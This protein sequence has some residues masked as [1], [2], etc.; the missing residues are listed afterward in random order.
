MAVGPG[1]EI[2]RAFIDVS[3]KS[4]SALKSLG[5]ISGAAAGAGAALAAIPAAAAVAGS[6]VAVIAGSFAGVGDAMDAYQKDQDAATDKMLE[7]KGITTDYGKAMA[8]LSPAQRELTKQLINMKKPI[9]ELNKVSAEAFLPGVTAMLKDSE[10]LFPIFK[11][12]LKDTGQIMGDTARDMGRLFKSQEFQDDLKALL[13]NTKPVTKAIGDSFVQLM[14]SVVDF[15]GSMKDTSKGVA[16]FIKDVSDGITGFLENL[17]PYD[18]NFASIWKSAG[19]IVKVVLPAVGSAIGKLAEAVDPIFS[20]IASFMEDHKDELDN[21]ILAILGFYGVIKG[22][23]VATA[24]GRMVTGVITAWGRLPAGARTAALGIGAAFVGIGI[25]DKLLP[26]VQAAVDADP[27]KSFRDYTDNQRQD[28]SDWWD[29]ILDPGSALADLK[30]ELDA[31]PDNFSHSPF[32][33]FFGTDL[34]NWWGTLWGKDGAIATAVTDFGGWLYT[35]LAVEPAQ[36]AQDMLNGIGMV[37][38]NSFDT[39]AKPFQDGWNSIVAWF[40]SFFGINS[41]STLFFG[42][43]IDIVTG[44]INGLSGLPGQALAIFNSAKDVAVAKMGEFRDWVTMIAGQ[45]VTGI[46][47]WISTLPISIS[48]WLGTARD[49]AVARMTEMKDGVVKG[50]QDLVFGL[51]GWFATL[52]GQARAWFNLAASNVGAAWDRIRELT[53]APVRF[54][55]DTVIN[56]GIVGVWN[57]LVDKIGV[58][59]RLNNVPLPFAAGGPVMGA[60]T[61]TSDSIPALLSN[62]E[63]VLTAREVQGLGGHAS[64][65]AIRAVARE[66]RFADGGAV[67]KPKGQGKV[68]G[69]GTFGANLNGSASADITSLFTDPVGF[70]AGKFNDVKGLLGGIPFAGQ[71]GQMISSIAGKIVDNTVEKAKSL[72]EGLFTGGGGG[73]G[74]PGTPGSGPVVDQVRAAMAAFGWASGPQWDALSWLISHESGWRPTAQN[75]TSTAY[76]LFQFLN[77]TWGSVGGSKTGNPGLQ[78]TYGARYIR[79][80]YGTPTGAKAFWQAHHWYDQGGILP[81]GASVAINGTGKPER[82]LTDDQ[83]KKVQGGN[84]YNITMQIDPTKVKSMDDLIRLVDNLKQTSRAGGRTL[85]GSRR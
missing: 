7:A 59:G 40:K 3:V 15:G 46:G 19:R 55:V 38:Q 9:D 77:S 25:A 31:F 64:V 66:N 45:A 65:E 2:G 6:A 82:V 76:G 75:P 14:G 62:G 37:F 54:V 42:F 61:A 78:A 73:G 10:G 49:W 72:V 26:E 74:A 1:F 30:G 4:A 60:G 68:I 84:T 79:S 50:A 41:P 23:G 48:N 33:Q 12:H 35:K 8:K 69:T 44:F 53:K 36:W 85:A 43:G 17:K 5:A 67:R 18:E 63:H 47:N 56:G 39:V 22:I 52:P 71:F 80:R 11:Q 13:A 70:I 34:P 32:M 29:A 20:K 58:G 83:W 21:W 81:P 16:G 28:L 57:W 24:V 51:I 27:F